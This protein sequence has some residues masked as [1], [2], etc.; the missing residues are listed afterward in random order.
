MPF[1]RYSQVPIKL[2]FWKIFENIEWKQNISA[3][4]G[5][6]NIL[7]GWNINDGHNLIVLYAMNIKETV[8]RGEK[9]ASMKDQNAKNLSEY[10]RLIKTL[11]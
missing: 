9:S 2:V 10:T 1:S 8:K 7:H 5:Y 3:H 4:I 6:F 11:E